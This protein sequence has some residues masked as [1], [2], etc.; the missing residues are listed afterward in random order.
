MPS[1]FSANNSCIKEADPKVAEVRNQSPWAL[2]PEDLS[3]PRC[4]WLAA[5]TAFPNFQAVFAGGPVAAGSGVYSFPSPAPMHD[6]TAT[7]INSVVLHANGTLFQQ[8]RGSGNDGVMMVISI[9]PLVQRF[10][11]RWSQLRA[12]LL[13]TLIGIVKST[14]C[15]EHW[16]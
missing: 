1:W 16:Q 13:D 15:S 9:V 4:R 7:A 12:H 8:G 2:R 3:S 10:E 5:W 11:G 6:F 14:Q